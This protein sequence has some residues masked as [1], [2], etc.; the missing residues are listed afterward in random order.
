MTKK[1][2]ERYKKLTHR[3]HI[4]QRPETYIG[5]TVT[6]LKKMFI[7]E[8]IN[9]IK[10]LNIVNQMVHYNPGF[11]K[12]FDEI[13][14]NASDHY[15]RTKKVKYI[16]V[17]IEKDHISIEND[18]PGIPVEIHKKEKIYVPELIFGHLL[19][20]ENYDDTE[21]RIVGGRNGYG[22]KLTNTYSTKFIVETADGT[23]KYKQEF[24]NNLEIKGKPKITKNK[25]NFTKITFYPDFNRFGLTEITEELQQIMLKRCV[26]ISVYCPNVKV[27]Y[28][29]TLIPVKTFK[30]YMKMYV[31]DQDYFYEKVNTSWEIGVSKSEDDLFQQISMVNSIS[32]YQGGTHVN[33]ITKQITKGVADILNKKY[34]NINI[35]E[36]DIKRNLF[37]FVNSKIVNPSFDTQTKENLITRMTQKNTEG[38][39][40]SDKFLKLLASSE[41][42]ESVLRYIEAK[43]K[44]SLA[45]ESGKKVSK[46]RIKKLDDANKAGTTQSQKCMLFLTEGDSALSTALSGFAV[47]GRDY[48]GA[49]PL[50]GKPLNVRDIAMDKIRANEEIKNIVSALG[51]EYGKKYKSTKDLRYGKVV[52]MS[53]QDLDGYHIKGLLINL[54]DTFWP[55][56]LQLDFLYEFITPIVKVTKGKQY[57]YFYRLEEYRKWKN[58][59]DTKG[60]FVKYYKG[61]GTIEPKESKRFF[62]NIA[63]HLIRFNYKDE[64]KTENL[65]DLA[66]NKK[67][68]EDRKKWLLNYNPANEIDK[69]TTKT[70]IDSFI[71]DELIE[72]SMADNIRSIPS[73]LDGLKPSQRKILFTMFLNNYKNEVKV[74]QLSGS[75]IDKSAYHHGPASLEQ[76]IVGMAQNFV[77]SNNINLLVPNGQFGTRIT[78]GKDSSAS[79]YIFTKLNKISNVIFDKRDTDVLN[80]NYDDGKK[81]EPEYYIPV[82]PMILVNGA[83]GIGTGYST[84]IT[85]FNPVDII[86]YYENK[87]TKKKTDKIIKPWFNGFKGEIKWDEEN[88][89]YLTKGIYEKLNATTIRITELPIGTWNDKYFDHLDKLI[90]RKVIKDYTKNCTDIEIDITI[91]IGREEIQNIDSINKVF[92]LISYISLDN[93][94]VM[95]KEG[96]IKKYKDQYE[97][98]DDFLVI[99]LNYYKLRKENMLAKLKREK[100]ILYNKMKFIKYILE[101]KLDFKNKKRVT[102]EKSMIELGL[103]KID[104]NLDY[105][106]NMNFLSLSNEKLRDL[107]NTYENK[108]S[109]IDVIQNISINKM[110]LTDLQ[111]VKKLL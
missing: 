61:L 22:S 57:K 35:K 72:F 63:K 90:D 93:L 65:I 70:T 107:K 105:L 89:R 56:L 94:N 53:D 77:G 85:Q 20:G 30:D 45:K 98:L 49:F 76:G 66:F 71:D 108:K 68:A 78:G 2:E 25:K 17:I 42:M 26:D 36:A 4:L 33:F 23:N 6:E 14:T 3:E 15:I 1:L 103:K 82:I 111:N 27:Y 80:H 92:N 46:V 64:E 51:L 104:D 74:N 41:I 101:D 16:K 38:V 50:K 18:G 99:R 44:S 67:R 97:I 110:W 73:L 37:I 88:G 58:S 106:L 84:D 9:D 43:E 59:S 48:Y 34:K 40:I 39:N 52:I 87:L 24:S 83:K 96:K 69:F 13:I 109:E 12:I 60:F 86:E 102:I 54:F 100:S 31:E 55:E 32:T 5:S 7:I 21:E 29:N 75:I 81:I 19:T 8:D 11:I 79:R 47:T 91:N 10:N 95:D 62:K 28:N